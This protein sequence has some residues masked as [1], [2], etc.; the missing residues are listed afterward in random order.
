MI[1]DAMK[2]FDF[3]AL[4]EPMVEFNQTHPGRPDYL[5]GFGG[6]TS[7]ATL[8]A[9]RA[10]ARTAYLSRLGDDPWGRALLALWSLEGVNTEAVDIDPTA[11]TGVYFVTHGPQGH[12]FS[13]LR[14][15]SAASRMTPENLSP[16]ARQAIRDA[17]WLH[18]SGISLAI[19]TI[20]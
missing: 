8:A 16:V 7:N 3:V 14:A 20:C 18:V 5:Q 4:G 13:Y 2:R 15:G 17:H 12:E 6:D 19:S 11:A 1:I 9:A 10:G